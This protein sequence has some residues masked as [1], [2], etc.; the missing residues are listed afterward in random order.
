MLDVKPKRKRQVKHEL[1]VAV[2]VFC[3]RHKVKNS[4]VKKNMPILKQ[5]VNF[6]TDA[7]SSSWQWTNDHGSW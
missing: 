5:G 1:P 6:S 4:T 2:P 7:F 3:K